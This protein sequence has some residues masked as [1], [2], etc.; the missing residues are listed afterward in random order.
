[1]KPLK[2]TNSEARRFLVKYHGLDNSNVFSGEKGILEYIKRVGCVQYDPLDVVGRNADLVFQARIKEYSLAYLENLLYKERSLIDGWDKMMS[3]YST[4][5]WP[6]FQRL[7][8]AKEEELRFIL[9][10]RGSLD[11]LLHVDFIRDLMFDK[12]PLQSTQVQLGGIG[13]G[14][15][16]QKNLS[17]VAMDFMF[18]TGELGIFRKK[19][20][21]KVYDLIE[22]LLPYEL[23]HG[24]APF[25]NE[26]EFY[27]WYFKRRVGSSG[28]LWKRNG[29]GWLGHFL[30]DKELR[31][32][33]L[34]ELV[35]D[36]K[37][38]M[39]S[40]EGIEDIF[41]IRVED[42]EILNKTYEA[43]EKVV[44]ILAPLDNLIW[45][46]KMTEEI[47]NFKYSWE[48]YVPVEKRKFGYY[49]L[50]V[51]YGDQIVARFEPEI[52]RG[53]NP[54]VIKNWWWEEGVVISEELNSA[55][56]KELYAFSRYLQADGVTEE[57][58]NKIIRE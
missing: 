1:M 7:R 47:F 48:V 34:S 41:Y 12:G 18:N 40:I 16:G 42:L 17:G 37:L 52:H 50:P 8:K 45:D 4:S 10:R 36:H 5:D 56:K 9:Q 21:Q 6:Y 49:V 3:I 55:I 20:T 2:I 35:E 24:T 32:S 46:R 53:S 14:R 33:I 19:N 38:A 25:N 54:F 43:K 28:L 51:L 29:G 30:S 15:W 58:L 11:A 23:L 26:R 22:R 27:K 13:H 39:I 44:R 31:A 57:S